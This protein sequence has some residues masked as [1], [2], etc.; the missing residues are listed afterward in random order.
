M[1]TE[2]LWCTAHPSPPHSI[3]RLC[4]AVERLGRVALRGCL[5]F[6]A[7]P[8]L[9]S[10][11]GQPRLAPRQ[12]IGALLQ[13][14]PCVVV[15]PPPGAQRHQRPGPLCVL[16]GRGATLPSPL[17]RPLLSLLLCSS[18]IRGGSAPPASPPRRLL[19][20]SG[21]EM[22]SVRTS[23]HITS[24]ELHPE[25]RGC[26]PNH[27]DISTWMGT[28]LSASVHPERIHRLPETCIS[29]GVTTIHLAAQGPHL[30]LV[31]S[32]ALQI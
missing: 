26:T 25:L 3:P 4:F 18:A 10:P 2:M 14:R 22:P 16:R 12:V 9:L 5:S 28:G 29:V 7:S 31:P 32:L 20:S 8:S 30:E 23:T 13:P 6:P 1:K 27:L 21:C 11:P 15:P 17:P 24:S 19:C